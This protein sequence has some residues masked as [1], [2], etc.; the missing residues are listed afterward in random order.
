MSPACIALTL[1]IMF[2]EVTS[3]HRQL[4]MAIEKKTNFNDNVKYISIINLVN[5]S[6]SLL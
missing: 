4:R 2:S 6:T 1:K 5:K 3:V